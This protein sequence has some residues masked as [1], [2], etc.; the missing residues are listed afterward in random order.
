MKTTFFTLFAA[1]CAVGANAS[2]ATWYLPA[3]AYGAC[4]N[5]NQNSD[6]VAALSPTEYA[7]G[8]N[9][10][11]RIAVHYQG[12]TVDVTVADL[13]P[14]CAVGH[15]DLSQGAF[16]QLASLDVGLLQGVTYN[17]I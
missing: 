10:G 5:Q 16:Q 3:G 14:S 15:I 4:G 12:R 9:C 1:L 6:F 7:S 8:A 17:Y 2:T 11:R 13:C